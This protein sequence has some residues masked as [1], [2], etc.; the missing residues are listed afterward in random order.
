M[1]VFELAREAGV[2]SADVIKAAEAAGVEA[3]NAIASD[4]A[5]DAEKLRAAL[6]GA[7]NSGLAAKRGS[8]ARR[9]RRR[10]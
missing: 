6:A 4:D 1:R 5:S 7:D 9:R 2:S 3:P 8:K 10:S